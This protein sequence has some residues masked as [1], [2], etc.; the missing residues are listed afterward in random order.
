[1]S[2]VAG[3][4]R[5]RS[6]LLICCVTAYS[7]PYMSHRIL[8]SCASNVV[9]FSSVNIVELIVLAWDCRMSVLICSMLS[10]SND[11]SSYPKAQYS[12]YVRCDEALQSISGVETQ[13]YSLEYARMEYPCCAS[14]PCARLNVST[15]EALLVVESSTL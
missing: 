8:R 7:K 11:S 6:S 13:K 1:M 2:R 12:R 14:I 3:I 15:A 10:K 4:M 5:W 9:K